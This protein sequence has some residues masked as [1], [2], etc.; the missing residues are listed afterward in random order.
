MNIVVVAA[1]GNNSFGQVF[2]PAVLSNVIAVGATNRWDSHLSGSMTGDHVDVV[3]P[4]ENIFTTKINDGYTSVSG[5][6]FSTPLVSGLASLLKGYNTSLENDDICH[7]IRLSAKK[8]NGLGSN[9]FDSIYGYGRID[10]GRA[11]SFLNSP[12]KLVRNTATNGV[13]VN[14][15]D[16]E[17][18]RFMSAAGLNSNYYSIKRVEVQKTIDLPNNLY[19]I[20]GVWGRGVSSTGWGAG[21]PNFGEG[22]CEVVPG[23]ITS[24]SFTLRTYVY[25]V[26]GISG[27]YFGYHPT[28]PANAIFAYSVLGH[29]RP[30]ISGPSDIC[31]E[32][33]GTYEIENLPANAI[34]TWSKSDNLEWASMNNNNVVVSCSGA[35]SG[36]SYDW[37]RATIINNSDTVEIEKSINAC[38]AGVTING[39]NIVT[40]LDSEIYSIN[41]K[42]GCCPMMLNYEWWLDGTKVSESHVIT[43][44][45]IPSSLNNMP[46]T[47]SYYLLPPGGA[48]PTIHSL[49]LRAKNSNGDLLDSDTKTITIYGNYSL[50]TPDVDIIS[51]EAF[52]IYPNPVDDMLTVNSI[53]Y[54]RLIQNNNTE[55][56]NFSNKKSDIFT[57]LILNESN[58]LIK[59][60][61]S[62]NQITQISLQGLPVGIYFVNIL[63]DGKIIHKQIIEKK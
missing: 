42:S 33:N 7:L 38:K 50:L 57:V 47:S 34:V 32:Y 58:G 52:A 62:G 22:F 29:I 55:C 35:V 4:G 39:S 10:A 19:N 23:S 25:E 24:T 16:N 15:S 63:K 41:T 51:P 59:K 3:A 36:I 31:P 1:M 17:T 21:N 49:E 26:W 2:Y 44:R 9:I 54:N 61:E 48:I 27:S 11:L 12:Y 60:V 8:V 40:Y 37:L 20:V 30:T 18:I 53:K 13:A 5:T 6:S 28:S 43:I 56:N 45:S 14:V 46:L